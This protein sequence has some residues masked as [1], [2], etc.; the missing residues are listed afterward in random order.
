MK[1]QKKIM[2]K[3]CHIS[4]RLF[5]FSQIN[6]EYKT[7]PNLNLKMLDTYVIVWVDQ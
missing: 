4:G 1:K 6:K 7:N 2:R 5:L 3:A